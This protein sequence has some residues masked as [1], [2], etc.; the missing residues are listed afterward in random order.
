MSEKPTIRQFFARFPTGD[1][2][3]EHIM[4]VRYGLRHICQACGKEST[5]HKLTERRAYSCAHC[6]AH[7]FPCAGTAFEDSRTALQT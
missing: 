6:G 2:C 7:I 3:L 4:E 1:A 5:F